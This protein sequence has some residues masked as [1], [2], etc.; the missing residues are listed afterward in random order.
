MPTEPTLRFPETRSALDRYEGAAWFD[1]LATDAA[2]H[3]LYA[4]ILAIPD[5]T[6]AEAR[7]CDTALGRVSFEETGVPILDGSRPSCAWGTD[8]DSAAAGI[9]GPAEL[10]VLMRRDFTENSNDSYWMTNPGHPLTGFPTIVGQSGV[11]QMGASGADLGL[12]TRSAL[13]MIMGRISG[14]DG[15]GPPGFT[16]QDMKNLLYSDIQYGA[17]LVK[18]QLVTMCRSFPHGQAPT[19]NGHT[20]AVGNSCQ[21]LADWNGRENPGSRGAELFREFW[22]PDDLTPSRTGVLGLD[23]P[24]RRARVGPGLRLQLHPGR[25]LDHR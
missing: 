4:D 10:P 25:H 24:D 7:R 8:R 12:R 20:I 3:A 13:H 23:L 22:Y 15:L 21:I 2:G 9:F 16:L 1:T 18:S 19:S 17:T 5:V 14:T 11:D 6:N